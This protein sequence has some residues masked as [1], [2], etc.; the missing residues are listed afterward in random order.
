MDATCTVNFDNCRAVMDRFALEL[1]TEETCA[2]D[3][4]KRQPIVFQA[5][6][7]LLAYA[8]LYKAGCSKDEDGNYCMYHNQTVAK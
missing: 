1:D 2:E 5:Y 7:G 8:P 6:H 3:L 4:E